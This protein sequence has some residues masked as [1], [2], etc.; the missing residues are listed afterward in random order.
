MSFWPIGPTG[1]KGAFLGAGSI[2]VLTVTLGPTLGF[3]TALE[4]AGQRVRSQEATE[5]LYRRAAELAGQS[6]ADIEDGNCVDAEKRLLEIERLLPDNLFQKINLALCISQLDR[7]DEAL[8]WLERARGIAPDN[9][10]ALF[11]TARILET[12]LDKAPNLALWNQTLDRFERSWPRDPRPHFLRA[13]VLLRESRA[14]EA[15]QELGKA[16]ALSRENLPLL[17]YQLEAAAR[18]KHPAASEDTLNALE[19][20]LNG[21]D[22][23]ANRFADQLRDAI[24][25]KDPEALLPPALILH[26]LLRPTDLY[27]VGLTELLGRG[28]GVQFFPQLDF[29]PPLP[30][31]IQGGQDIAISF[32]DRSTSWLP[33]ITRAK[34]LMVVGRGRE[35]NSALLLTDSSLHE[36]SSSASGMV[37]AQSTSPGAV[38][39]WWGTKVPA[40]A[41][42]ID[43]DQDGEAELVWLSERALQVAKI[44]RASGTTI[45]LANP[46]VVPL[47]ETPG[48]VAL[49]LVAGDIDQEGD[50]DLFVLRTV[51]P[52]LLLRNRGTGGFAVEPIELGV[53]NASDLAFVDLDDDG[54]LDLVLATAQGPRV[55][56]NR[57]QGVYR[58]LSAQ[59]FAESR[60]RESWPNSKAGKRRIDV[61]DLDNDGQ[62]D[63]L[64]WGPGG[65]VIARNLGDHFE[66]VPLPAGES[67]VSATVILDLDNDGDRDLLLTNE[68]TAGASLLRNRRDL[69][70]ERTTI[71]SEVPRGVANVI[72]GDFDLD[73]DLDLLFSG[74]WGLRA[75]ANESGNTNHWLRVKL[76][77]LNDN[78]SKNNILGHSSRIEIRSGGAFQALLAD[79][80]ISHFGLGSNR[81][82]EVLRVVWTNGLAQTQ[83]QVSSNQTLLERQVLKGSC[84]FLYTWTG[85]RFEFHTDLL[86]RSTL[87]MTFADGSAAP[88]QSA[89]DAVLI[90]GDRLVAASGRYWLN[91]TAELWETIYLDRQELLVL[92]HP[93]TMTPVVD[94]TFRAPPHPRNPIIHWATDLRVPNQATNHNG[95]DI[96]SQLRE[97]DERYVDAFRLTRYQGAS[98][99]HSI[100]LEF[101]DLPLDGARTLLLWG[102]IFPTDTSINVALAQDPGLDVAPPSLEVWS[103]SEWHM[104]I[105]SLGLPM[106]KRKAMVIP[107]DQAM[108]VAG[109]PA[110]LDAASTLRLRVSTTMQIYWD[111]AALSLGREQPL[112]R[113][114]SLD[115]VQPAANDSVVRTVRLAPV[116]ADLHYRGFSEM[117]RNSSSGPHLFDYESVSTRARFRDLTG[118]YTTFGDVLAETLES[119]DSYVIMNSGD[120]LSLAYDASQLP[121]LRPGWS[122]NFVLLSDGWVKDADVNTTSSQTVEPLPFHSMTSYPDPARDHIARLARRTRWVDGSTFSNT[123]RQLTGV[124]AERSTK[125]R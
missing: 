117:Y 15:L 123:L 77:G 63:L 31:S 5:E 18:S 43:T 52:P 14:T 1:L 101:D 73:G 35:F 80:T 78:N 70:F 69:G 87:G 114:Q 103:G 20:R 23:R 91:T 44:E 4:P 110:T 67:A 39:A 65:S 108:A 104:V 105:P 25:A 3:T 46:T 119:D 98:E 57:R 82:A 125:P 55:L 113:E 86:W 8:R 29:D 36:L 76:L 93:S 38:K 111:K 17:L 7:S 22:D 30:K 48:A 19:D 21:F 72:S 99:R 2:L 121:H 28:D 115:R 40:D 26:N 61:A 71:A 95:G 37:H 90:P 11:A 9:P 88:H 34:G 85:E 83:Q 107:L 64:L 16:Q 116:F 112:G 51:G 100:E 124:V 47:P 96:T 50:L 92:D 120:E 97:R 32:T 79:G 10:Q 60:F 6:L 122:R 42:A 49:R 106:G 41:L 68:A 94:E 59:W 27:A 66:P 62:F 54:D 75:V 53:E 33:G 89:R 45:A 84:P 56:D 24:S 74:P 118:F 109:S 81:R 12:R 102:W 58:D 13:T